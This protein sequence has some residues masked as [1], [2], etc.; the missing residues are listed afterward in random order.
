[1]KGVGMIVGNFELNPK[2]ATADRA[3]MIFGKESQKTSTLN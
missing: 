3:R 2:N 1:M